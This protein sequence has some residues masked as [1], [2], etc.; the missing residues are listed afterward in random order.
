MPVDVPLRIAM[1]G[2]L[3]NII[4]MAADVTHGFELSQQTLIILLTKV[5]MVEGFIQ[6]K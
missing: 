5:V 6:I 2:V 3:K 1:L 4:I